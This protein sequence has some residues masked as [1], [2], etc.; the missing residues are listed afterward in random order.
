[1][2]DHVTYE[3]PL[4]ALVDEDIDLTEFFA[5][6]EMPEV[7]PDPVIEADFQVRWWASNGFAIHLVESPNRNAPVDLGLAHFCAVV[8]PSGYREAKA[9]KWHDDIGSG[10]YRIWLKGPLGIRVELREGDATGALEDQ[11]RIMDEALAIY[12]ERNERYV[13]NW[14]RFGWRGCLFRLRERVERAWDELWDADPEG[15]L[16]DDDLV[17]LINFAAF[18]VRAIRERN[19]D[20][21]WWR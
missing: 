9:S 6:L 18:T 16:H 13:D 20:G 2:I 14:R 7:E 8:S 19:R 21:E 4:G 15:A 12:T 10:Q 11:R 5:A 3:V 1:M 17:D